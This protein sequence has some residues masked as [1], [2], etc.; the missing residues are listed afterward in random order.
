MEQSL[1]Y[2]L[3]KAWMVE[4]ASDGPSTVCRKNVTTLSPY[5]SDVHESI[6]II[7]AQVLL[8]K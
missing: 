5:N 8:R 3:N 1:L 4:N 7:L 2:A 6:S